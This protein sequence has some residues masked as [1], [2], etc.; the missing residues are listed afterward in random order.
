MLYFI[1]K[2]IIVPNPLFY[3][4]GSMFAACFKV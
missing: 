2:I 4:A 3:K 1:L